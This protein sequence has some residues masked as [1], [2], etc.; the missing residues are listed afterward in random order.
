MGLTSTRSRSVAQ[1]APLPARYQQSPVGG[2]WSRSAF[3]APLAQLS[4]ALPTGVLSIP[5]FDPHPTITVPVLLFTSDVPAILRARSDYVAFRITTGGD[6]WDF[7]AGFN[8]DEEAQLIG[9]VDATPVVTQIFRAT[10]APAPA[11]VNEGQI[12]KGT[13]TTGA[14]VV[15]GYVA[16]IVLTDRSLVTAAAADA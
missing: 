6:T 3:F 5:T 7:P 14:V 4:A 13:T 16:G 1:R 10:P 15:A 8:F 9:N 11:D 2:G 12:V